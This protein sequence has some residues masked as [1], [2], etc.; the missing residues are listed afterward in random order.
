M[1]I[2]TIK[3]PNIRETPFEPPGHAVEYRS[4]RLRKHPLGPADAVKLRDPPGIKHGN[5]PFR[6]WIILIYCNIFIVEDI[7][8]ADNRVIFTILL[9]NLPLWSMKCNI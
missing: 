4:M 2:T 5:Q 1:Y 9:L 7:L 3:D 8:V 6:L